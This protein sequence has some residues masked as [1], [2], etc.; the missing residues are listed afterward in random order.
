MARFPMPFLFVW[1]YLATGK[2]VVQLSQ[3]A[4]KKGE[5]TID[6]NTPHL[7]KSGETLLD[8]HPPPG[9][10]AAGGEWPGRR[11]EAGNRGLSQAMDRCTKAFSHEQ[12]CP[13]RVSARQG[14]GMGLDGV[15][16]GWG[17]GP[18]TRK[19]ICF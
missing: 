2:E 12:M 10:G 13:H 14:I 5:L 1:F 7:T 11:G 19:C 18:L 3:K 9:L 15:V 17:K 16:L 4:N 8:H 6:V